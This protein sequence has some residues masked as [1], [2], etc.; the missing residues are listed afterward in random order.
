MSLNEHLA[1]SYAR[2]AEEEKRHSK[3]NYRRTKP[4]FHL[5]CS[6]KNAYRTRAIALMTAAKLE[7]VLYVYKCPH[8]REFHL[9]KQ[10]Q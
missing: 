5:P 8:C 10:E 4:R 1:G 3:R 7:V 6:H 9:T 2:M